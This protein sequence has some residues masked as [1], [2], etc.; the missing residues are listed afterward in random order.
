MLN[1]ISGLQQCSDPTCQSAIC[2]GIMQQSVFI[3]LYII[4]ILWQYFSLLSLTQTLTFCLLY[5]R[6]QQSSSH[7]YQTE[8][9]SIT[10]L[11]SSVIQTAILVAPVN[12]RSAQLILHQHYAALHT[13]NNIC[14]YLL[15]IK[16]CS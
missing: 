1:F 2:I 16:F 3:N 5:C 8:D 11:Q 10:D 9:S 13:I 6:K 7:E 12:F 4:V 14:I 15:L